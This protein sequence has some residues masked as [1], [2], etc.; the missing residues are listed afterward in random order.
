MNKKIKILHLED[1]LKDS[2]LIRSLIEIGE[3]GYDYFLADNEKDFLNI[4][5]TENIDIILSDYRMPYYNGNEALKVVKEKYSYI[6]F[7]FVSGAM[8][9]DAA[10][11]AMLNG[12]TDYVLKNKLERLVPAIK[13]AMYEYELETKRKQSEIN[14]KEKNELIEEQNDKNVQIIK[15]LAFQNEEKEKRAAELTIAD[16]ELIFQSKEKEKRAAELIIANYELT[17]QNNEKEKRAAELI[18]ANEELTF[19]NTEKEKRAA[20]L[21]IANKE[22]AFQNEEKEKRAA[23]LIIANK[24]LA[25]QNKEK[26]KRAAELIIANEELTFQNEEKE[27]RAAELIIANKELAFQN[28]EKE[29]RAAELIIANKELAFQNEE[30]EKRAAELFIANKELTFQNEEKEK[31]A[32]ELIIANKELEKAKAK[33]EE[34]DRIKSLFLTNLSHELRTPLNSILGFSQLINGAEDKQQI[35]EFAKVINKEG[36]LLFT[37][38]EDLIIVSSILSKNITKKIKDIQLSNL[39]D[40]ARFIINDEMLKSNKEGLTFSVFEKT[41]ED[42]VS[43]LADYDMFG[44][45]IRRLVLNAIKFTNNGKIEVGYRIENENNIIFYVSDTGIGIPVEKQDIIFDVFRQVEES[46]A[47]EFGGIGSGLAICKSFVE[48][49]NGTVWV[50]SQLGKGSTFYLKLPLVYEKPDKKASPLDISKN[51][52]KI[53]MTNNT[54]LIVDDVELNRQYLDFILKDMGVNVILAENGKVALDLVKHTKSIDLILMDLNMPVMDGYES[55][56]LIKKIRPE[57]P[58]IFQTAYSLPEHIEKAFN[59][60]CDAFIK[61]PINTQEL[62]GTMNECLMKSKAR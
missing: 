25:F 38:I 51:M 36:N 47:R 52:S 48:K 30:K 45:I 16:K 21:I 55:T 34:N 2:E 44:G 57:I 6:P 41:T 62:I 7:I 20:E 42:S 1:S 8:G 39:L 58:V 56:R 24:E 3:I 28:Q 22:L 59:S 17:F 54:V 23:E 19:Q 33:A 4:L 27:K 15:E 49:M 37:I 29:K 26:E 11:N 18:I 10:I 53:D 9:E 14:L 60:G 50:E 61:K 12:A 13:R 35:M 5:E 43:V 46:S 40:K 32:A 31:R